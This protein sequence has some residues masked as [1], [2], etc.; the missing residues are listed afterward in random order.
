MSSSKLLEPQS[1]S[2]N[3]PVEHGQIHI[4]LPTKNSDFVHS[5]RTPHNESP[6]LSQAIHEF[7][8]EYRKQPPSKKTMQHSYVEKY[9]PLES[10]PKFNSKYVNSEG[11][12]NYGMLLEDVDDIGGV[13]A[14]RHTEWL[15]PSDIF[16]PC[17]VGTEQIYG[18][19]QNSADD[20]KLV[21]HV[22]YT[23]G[24]LM[25]CFVSLETFWGKHA[26]IDTR[27]LHPKRVPPIGVSNSRTVAIFSVTMLF[28]DKLT[29]RLSPVS[30][31]EC[32][33]AQEEYI[34]SQFEAIHSARKQIINMNKAQEQ[35][36][37]YG[38]E[39]VNNV[40]SRVQQLSFVPDGGSQEFVFISD[41]LVKSN[42][43]P[44][45]QQR[46]SYGVMFGGYVARASYE[47]ACVGASY[48]LRSSEFRASQLND[49]TF[50]LP[51][52]IG[53]HVRSKAEIIY[54]SD[55]LNKGFVTRVVVEA[56]SPKDLDF[57][58][59]FIMHITFVP[60][61]QTVQ[62]KTVLPKTRKES[63][64]WQRGHDIVQTRNEYL[65]EYINEIRYIGFNFC[66][67]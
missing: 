50:L 39:L 64:L 42:Y 3:Q 55:P 7:S 62:R 43:V 34:H 61:D 6:A 32:V 22:A 48:F 33:T 12:I 24:A 38:N 40:G 19:T 27:I 45:P 31:I 46:N 49:I 26:S 18:N 63:I 44:T 58:S 54:S 4:V 37:L 15:G 16:T 56:R 52:E 29:K 21:G 25:V 67:L 5:A 66:K 47:L 36:C 14:T 20:Y 17:T 65:S 9:L 53:D 1:I 51:I 59:A 11:G 60:T 13:V 30:Q 23:K 2:Y 28:F 35:L 41:T 57:K 10:S 8:T